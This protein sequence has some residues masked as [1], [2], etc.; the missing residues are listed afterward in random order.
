M[1]REQ[2]YLH[3]G[4]CIPHCPAGFSEHGNG[5]FRRYCAEPADADVD[6]DAGSD[7]DT[8]TDTEVAP[9]VTSDCRPRINGCHSCANDESG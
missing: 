9:P 6:A 4:Q 5:R 3:Q 7:T 1:C 8:G 2:Q